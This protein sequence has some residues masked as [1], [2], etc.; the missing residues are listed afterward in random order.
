MEVIASSLR[1]MHKKPPGRATMAPRSTT[2]ARDTLIRSAMYEEEYTYRRH[3][4]E[5]YAQLDSLTREWS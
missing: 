4:T 1:A 5:A 2:E 3:T